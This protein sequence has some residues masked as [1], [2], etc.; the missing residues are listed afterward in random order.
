MRMKRSPVARCR[1]EPPRSA[2]TVL[3]LAVVLGVI[4][5]LLSLAASGIARTQFGTQ[6]SRCLNNL[7]QLMLAW[8]M[9][10]EDN[11]GRLPASYSD[12][13]TGNAPTA[14]VR[15]WLDW[16]TSSDNTNTAYLVD[17]RYSQL[18][19]YLNRAADLFQCPADHYISPAQS[20]LDWTRRT[21]SYSAN[22][23]LGQT[24]YFSSA[25]YKT[26]V[27]N[28]EFFY[29]GAAD[30]WVLAEEHPDSINDSGFANPNPRWVDFPAIHHNG[31]GVFAMADGHAE[32]HKWSGSLTNLP[33]RIGGGFLPTLG[34]AGEPDVHWV[35]WRAGRLSPTSY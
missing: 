31:A 15:G 5:G 6:T 1:R 3:E 13:L 16:T 33:L 32:V 26:I 30:T 22:L 34:R 7:R 8:Q 4:A 18:A 25:P 2:F 12:S 29:P 35:S 27:K 14:W 28:S 21:R 11:S 10:V 20:R 19:R 17:E 23:N 9:Y 24:N